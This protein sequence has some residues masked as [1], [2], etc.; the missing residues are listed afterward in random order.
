MFK[1]MYVYTHTYIPVTTIIKNKDH[2]S[3]T[4]QGGV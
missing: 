1:N 4:E 3:E 2:E